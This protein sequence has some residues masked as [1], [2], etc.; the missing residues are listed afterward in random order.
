MVGFSPPLASPAGGDVLS[1]LTYWRV[2]SPPVDRLKVFIHLL[3][4]HGNLISQH[5]GLG[6]PPQGWSAGD[7]IVQKHTLPLPGES[8]P[9]AYTLQM[10]L[11][12][13]TDKG[14]R[15]SALTADHL[16]LYSS[17]VSE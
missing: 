3:D 14:E 17:E 13:D 12:Y 5:D 2:Q 8:L 7:L 10:G 11:Y 4:Q 6:S 1:L 16:L 15:L 9:E